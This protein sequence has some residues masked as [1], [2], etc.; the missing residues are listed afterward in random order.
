MGQLIDLRQ[1]IEQILK[2]TIGETSAPL[3]NEAMG[4]QG[5]MAK[6]I[7]VLCNNFIS[8]LDQSI[9]YETKYGG[10]Y[11]KTTKKKNSKYTWQ[12]LMEYGAKVIY[13]IR[14]MLTGE[15]ISFLFGVSASKTGETRSAI[16]SQSQILSSLQKVSKNAIGIKIAQLESSLQSLGSIEIQGVKRKNQ[17]GDIQNLATVDQYNKPGKELQAHMIYQKSKRDAQVYVKFSGKN[18]RQTLYYDINNTGNPVD[19]TFFNFG[20]LWEWY[21]SILMGEDEVRYQL[22]TE[23]IEQGSLRGIILQS[24]RIAGTKQGDFIDA[25]YR[26]IQAKFNNEKIISYN[27]IKV[28]MIQLCAAL[29]DYIN[30]T[31]DREEQKNNLIQVL[32]RHFFPDGTLVGDNL[33]NQAAQ[34]L[35]SQLTSAI[36]I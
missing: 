32:Q 3:L 21:N 35:I 25:Q 27:N 15:E 12:Q 16:V 34:E 6:T 11:A 23:Q 10:F 19:F 31:G 26:Q 17:W 2:S 29:N 5:N 30:G 33:A 36:K 13:L 14:H 9:I 24:D 8:Q 20:W 7:L 22:V 1:E 18:S 28:I 4:P